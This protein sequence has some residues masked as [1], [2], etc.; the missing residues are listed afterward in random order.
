MTQLMQA[1]PQKPAR[2]PMSK[3]AVLSLL[4]RLPYETQVGL[5]TGLGMRLMIT[6]SEEKAQANG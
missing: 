5:V 2:I 4:A 1:A 3:D 6:D